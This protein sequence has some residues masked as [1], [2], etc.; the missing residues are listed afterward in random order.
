MKFSAI[1]SNCVSCNVLFGLGVKH[2]SEKLVMVEL[3]NPI[4]PKQDCHG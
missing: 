4:L 3:T 1:S 2:H